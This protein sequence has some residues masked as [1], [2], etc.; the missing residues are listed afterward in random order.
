MFILERPYVSRHML[1]YAVRH[2]VPV[3][4]TSFTEAL[5]R[6]APLRLLDDD[7]FAARLREGGRLYTSSEN[8]LDWVFTHCGDSDLARACRVM[9]DKAALRRLLRPMFPDFFFREIA[10][11]DLPGTDPS[12]LRFPCVLKPSVGFF[13]LGVRTV[14]SAGDWKAAVR[15]IQRDMASHAGLFP[16]SV[17]EQQRFLAEELVGGEEFAV[18][19]YFDA[20]GEPVILNIFQHR[21]A[22]ADDVSDR[23][24]VTGKDVIEARME[25]FMRFFRQ[26]NAVL[27]VRDFPAHVELR[28]DRGRVLPIEFNPLRCA[29][30]CC[31][32]LAH[33]AYGFDTYD[34]YLRGVRPDF[35][36]ILRGR[37]GQTYSMII[38]DRRPGTPAHARLDFD[39]LAGRLQDVLEVR[40]MQE[41]GLPLFG[42][43][44]A[45][46]DDAHARQL[47][48]MLHSDL[49]EFLLPAGEGEA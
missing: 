31:T 11:A 36:S 16:A 24:Y 17:L 47:D 7:A 40:P 49:G 23:L 39:R 20:A 13:S 32:D 48:A 33:Y 41:L 6:T 43:V 27:G 5:A 30:M 29:G 22:S 1:D 10:A 9:K 18:D 26:A 37:E 8:A 28:V 46:T 14:P 34:C 2:A 12:G 21:F 35:G 19:L 15:D 44:F 4:R 3:L 45:R 38:L 25:E 42:I